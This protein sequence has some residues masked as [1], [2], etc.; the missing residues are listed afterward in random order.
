MYHL[1]FLC[2]C[3][4]CC[5]QQSFQR[6]SVPH[7]VPSVVLCQFGQSFL[8]LSVNSLRNSHCIVCCFGVTIAT[9]VFYSLT[10]VCLPQIFPSLVL[11]HYSHC[12][13]PQSVHCLSVPHTVLS[14][15]TVP[16]Y[17]LLISAFCP[18][19]VSTSR[20]TACWFCVTMSTA[21]F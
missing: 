6:M 4:H 12:C 17:S 18:L 15:G 5:L 19:S 16:L 7:T 3:V 9:S 13:L 11:C 1:I 2:H 21:V 8:P 10:N 20:S 14:V